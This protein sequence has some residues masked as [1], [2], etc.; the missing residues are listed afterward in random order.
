M[1]SCRKNIILWTVA[2]TVLIEAVTI[3]LRFHS[4][5]SAIEFNTTAPLLHTMAEL[6]VWSGAREMSP[7]PPGR[8]AYRGRCLSATKPELTY[9]RPRSAYPVRVQYR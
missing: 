3:Y 6:L 7:L 2:S 5:V 9:N 1:G 4:G 8:I